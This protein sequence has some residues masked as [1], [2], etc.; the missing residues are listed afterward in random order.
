MV[1]VTTYSHHYIIIGIFRWPSL[2]A[3]IILKTIGAGVLKLSC[4]QSAA[5]TG[6]KT[7]QEHKAFMRNAFM[8]LVSIFFLKL[9]PILVINMM[10]I[11]CIFLCIYMDDVH[12][13]SLQSMVGK[14]NQNSL[15]LNQ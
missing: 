6:K 12:V 9:I 11:C 1:Y 7:D 8:F 10:F 14:F 2:I 3:D 4:R 15:L 5:K 13:Q